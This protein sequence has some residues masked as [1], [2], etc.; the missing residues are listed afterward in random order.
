M[1]MIKQL[2]TRRAEL[3][4]TQQQLTEL[5]GLSRPYLSGI[6]SENSSKDVR[7]STLEAVAAGLDAEWVLVPR[8]L[9]PEVRR[10]LS[11]K[12]VGPDQ[13]PSAIERMLGAKP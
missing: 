3:K 6:L 5:T 10:L 8:Q 4:R 7:A 2:R 11:G 9:A 1:T 12:T 13:V